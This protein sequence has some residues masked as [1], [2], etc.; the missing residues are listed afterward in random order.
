MTTNGLFKSPFLS[1]GIE[2]L[3]QLYFSVL[4]LIFLLSVV[5]ASADSSSS[6]DNFLLPLFHLRSVPEA[7]SSGLAGG[8]LVPQ[9]PASGEDNE[10]VQLYARQQPPPAPHVHARHVVRRTATAP[11]DTHAQMSMAL[12]CW[13]LDGASS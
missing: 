2:H 6:L 3:F 8:Q 12:C 7:V 5:M 4:L 10:V 13:R 9:L 11:A 1:S